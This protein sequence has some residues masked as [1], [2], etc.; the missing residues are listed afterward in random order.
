MIYLDNA[1]TTYPKPEC[2]YE[3]MDQA[4][5]TLA[6]NAG[7][8]S[9]KTAREA[10]AIIDEVKSAAVALFNAKGLAEVVLTPS[11]THA[12]N[13]V[14]HGLNISSDSVIYLSPYEHNAVARTV[15]AIAQKHQVSTVMLPLRDDLSIDLERTE[16]LFETKRPTV[17]V[18]NALSN[19]TGYIAPVRDIFAMAK[20]AGAITV[21]DASQAAGLIQLDMDALC[22]D[23]IC[24]AG[25]KTMM[26]PLGAAGFVVR[27]GV[28]L[29]PV[30]TGGTGSNSLNLDMP[31]YAPARY[32][33]SSPN[34]V[35]MAGLLAA[36]KAMDIEGHERH[37]RTLTEYLLDRLSD[38]PKV[39]VLGTEDNILGIVSFVVEGYSS[40]EVGAILDEEYDIAVRTGY[41]CAPY[42]HEYLN[43][44]DMNG[45]IRVGLGLFNST[46]DVDALIEALESL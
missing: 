39:S 14:L 27:N 36:L 13:Q 6:F 34:V 44:K 37:V 7:R 38:L 18:L 11:V 12:L 40:D 5:R 10:A 3:A 32:E 19:V 2:V 24:F 33:A 43:D 30:L 35:A 16:F 28:E 41:H 23:V 9:Y 21:L 26:G 8:G 15:N 22:A 45:T 17:V 31:D 1:A 25:H 29:Q 20:T 4:N 46:D 42:I